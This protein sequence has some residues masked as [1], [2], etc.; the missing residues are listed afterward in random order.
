MYWIV[1]QMINVQAKDGTEI[2]CHLLEWTDASF[3]SST[4]L[5][6]IILEFWRQSDLEKNDTVFMETI[7]NMKFVRFYPKSKLFPWHG[8]CSER[9]CS[10]YFC[11]ERGVLNEWVGIDV[12]LGRNSTKQMKGDPVQI[13]VKKTLFKKTNSLYPNL[14]IIYHKIITNICFSWVFIF[15]G[16]NIHNWEETQRWK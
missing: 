16:T 8:K 2:L 4:V 3:D 5:V 6:K 11:H 1:E 7:K 13:T 9:F 15:T 14:L 12:G 10:L